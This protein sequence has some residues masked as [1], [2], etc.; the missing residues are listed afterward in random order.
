MIAMV[1]IHSVTIVVRSVAIDFCCDR[2]YPQIYLAKCIYK[3]C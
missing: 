3:K 1:N 2:F